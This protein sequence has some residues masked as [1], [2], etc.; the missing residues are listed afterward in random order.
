MRWQIA[1]LVVPLLVAG[2]AAAS[3]SGEPLDDGMVLPSP[4]KDLGT[5]A[6]PGRVLS[7]RLGFDSVEGGCAYLETDDG[8]RYEVLYPDGW[9]VDL[10][11]AALLGPNGQRVA[12][13]ELLGV[14]GSIATDRSSIC[15]LG[16]IF[17][18][19]EVVIGG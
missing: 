3:R 2:C 6:G 15:Q 16:P 11:G 10:A 8:T 19:I 5:P 17:E 1:G 7:G 13:G 14:R 9:H 12:A 4:G 18:V